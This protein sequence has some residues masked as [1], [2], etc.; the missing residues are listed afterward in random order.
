MPMDAYVRTHLWPGYCGCAE[1]AD[2]QDTA[3]A[4]MQSMALRLGPGVMRRQTEMALNRPDYRPR[5]NAVRCPTLIVAGQH[6]RLCPPEAQQALHRALPQS[7]VCMLAD[8]GHLAVVEQPAE[9]ACAVAAWF[10][11]VLHLQETTLV[12]TAPTSGE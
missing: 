7:T 12:E 4:L 9:V 8:A 6:D 5:L 10:H 1:S 3:L 2:A 11:T